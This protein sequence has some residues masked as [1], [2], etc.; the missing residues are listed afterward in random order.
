MTERAR[1]TENDSQADEERI[2]VLDDRLLH[3]TREEAKAYLDSL[4]QDRGRTA[5]GRTTS[6]DS[7]DAE[8]SEA[9]SASLRR[10]QA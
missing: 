5:N 2:T 10:A 8:K 6:S 7:D 3:M 4:A 9:R 1:R